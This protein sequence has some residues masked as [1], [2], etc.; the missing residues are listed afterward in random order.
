LGS[1]FSAGSTE[2]S[3]A[4][5]PA[6]ATTLGTLALVAVAL[7]LAL[8]ATLANG[9]GRARLRDALRGQE[10]HPIAW[11]GGV[12]LLAMAGSLYFS[13]VVHLA[14]CSLCWYQRIAM[15]PLVFVLGVGAVRGDPGVWRYALPL[16]VV[17]LLISSYHVTIEWQPTLD[18][19]ACS[20]G[21]P[22]SARYFATFGFV[23]IATMAGAAFLLIISLM[24][25]LRT[26]EKQEGP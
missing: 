24:A 16:A 9:N 4:L 3:V 15:Y 7:A 23:S 5:Y 21:P 13:D 6:I 12:A 11:A 18:V 20:V 17:G 22:C 2:V 1:L 26:L 10:R 14:P 19:G 8:G 25:L